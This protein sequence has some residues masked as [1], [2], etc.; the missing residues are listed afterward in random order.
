MGVKPLAVID[1]EVILHYNY[2][3]CRYLMAVEQEFQRRLMTHCTEAGYQGLKLSFAQLI[4]QIT[5]QGTRVVDIA[6]HNSVSKQAIGQLANEIEALGYIRRLP[7]PT[8]KR[9]KLIQLTKQGI[10]L[11]KDSTTFIADIEDEFVALI[12]EQQLKKLSGILATLFKKLHL[13]SPA[14]GGIDE[15]IHQ[16]PGNLIVYLSAVA[17]DSQVRLMK[18]HHECGY[19]NLKVSYAQVLSYI[20]VNGARINDIAEINGVSKQAI[21]QITQEIESLGYLTRIVDPQDKRARKIIF[22]PKGQS[23]IRDSVRTIKQ[24]EADWENLIGTENLKTVVSLLKSLYIASHEAPTN[25]E[26]HAVKNHAKHEEQ[27][28]T[29]TS[30]I[31]STENQQAKGTAQLLIY[32]LFRIL[33]QGADQQLVH[34]NHAENEIHLAQQIVDLLSKTKVSIDQIERFLETRLG[35]RDK[36]HLLQLL[37]RLGSP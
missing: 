34:T 13:A 33:S 1:E 24:V 12:G 14:A 37:E 16:G 29:F 18:Y 17:Q 30:Q 25:P 15:V 10:D 8:D 9:S 7:D 31:L 23:L 26:Q 5:P 20:G 22:T 35:T 2:N 32:L 27:P 21:S 6:R 19:E 11:I 3:S 28:I 4:P 36:N